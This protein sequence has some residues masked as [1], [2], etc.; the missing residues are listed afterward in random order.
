MEVVPFPRG[1]DPDAVRAG[2]RLAEH[3]TQRLQEQL[4]RISALAEPVREALERN[5]VALDAVDAAARDLED[6]VAAAEE[7]L[8]LAANAAL[9]PPHAFLA[10]VDYD[11]DPVL[12]AALW[13]HVT[14]AQ[15]AYEAA[16][17]ERCLALNALAGIA[18]VADRAVRLVDHHPPFVAP[19]EPA[20]PGR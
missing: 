10:A 12:A 6:V 19:L 13:D 8:A 9:E 20:R 15:G 5:A 11:E 4:D 16:A 1:P 18:R 3:R 14:A 17:R 7:T 2:V